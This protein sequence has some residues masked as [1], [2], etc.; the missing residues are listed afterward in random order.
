M[1]DRE[2]FQEIDLPADVWTAR[3]V[4][5]AGRG[6]RA[7]ARVHQPGVSHRDLRTAR[8]GGARAAGGHADQPGGRAGRS[9]A[10]GQW[11]RTPG[12]DA[13]RELHAMLAGAHRTAPDA[14][15]RRLG[16]RGLCPVAGLCTKPP[17][18]RS[19]CR[20]AARTTST[21]AM[22]TTPVTSASALRP[23]CANSLPRQTRWS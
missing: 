3:E 18:C 16:S 9:T 20:F 2:A 5:R 4:G 23:R 21:T 15:R 17:T 13:L 12:P 10:T 6:R 11:N 14:R 1:A 7:P 19:A 8:T 22:R